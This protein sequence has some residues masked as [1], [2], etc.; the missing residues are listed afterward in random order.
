[1]RSLCFAAGLILFGTA[2]SADTMH[3]CSAAWSDMSAADKSSTTYAQY[4]KMCLSADYKV[5]A[6]S[7]PMPA[8][9]TGK[10]RDGTYTTA[11]VHSGACSRHG[12]VASWF[13][14]H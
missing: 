10:C 8:G 6:A 12:G 7:S 5:P 3:N 2:A 14:G 4:S 9:A 11:T 13:P 1:M